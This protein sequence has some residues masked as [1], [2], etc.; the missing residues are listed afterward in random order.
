ME[1]DLKKIASLSK[2]NQDEN[3]EFRTFLK[4]F[5]DK[6]IDSI[7]HEINQ[8]VSSKIDCMSCGNC[9]KII[10]PTLNDKEIDRLSKSLKIDTKE[11]EARYL[12]KD[13]SDAKIFNQLPCPFFKDNKCTQYETRPKDCVS[14]PHLHKNDFVFRLIGIIENSSICP[15]VFNVYEELKKALWEEWNDYLNDDEAF[16]DPDELDDY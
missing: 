5:D 14:F 6:E 7:V 10:R 4:G 16:D 1:T 2:F 13:E 3:W 9:C 12:E 8:Q 11:F 15:I